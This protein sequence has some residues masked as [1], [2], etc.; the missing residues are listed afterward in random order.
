MAP[1]EKLERLA[2]TPEDRV[3][4]AQRVWSGCRQG[5]GGTFRPSAAF[6][7]AGAGAGTPP[8]GGGVSDL[9]WGLR[10]S[11]AGGGLLSAPYL[12]PESL[13]AEGPVAC[14]APASLNKTP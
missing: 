9:F 4:L 13:Y 2:Q 3:L 10:R 8:D 6:H 7:P 11:G 1:R 12:E 5:S 14:I